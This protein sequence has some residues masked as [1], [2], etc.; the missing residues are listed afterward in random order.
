MPN[1]NV[2]A[3]R[4]NP[5][6]Q[7]R[8]RPRHATALV[9]LTSLWLGF[10]FFGV[11]SHGAGAD[12]GGAPQAVNLLRDPSFEKGDS[13][14]PRQY[15]CR[16]L[17]YM[18]QDESCGVLDDSAAY[19]GAKSLRLAPGQSYSFWKELREVL[20]GYRARYAFTFSVWLKAAQDGT[21]VEITAT[22]WAEDNWN[23]GHVTGHSETVGTGWARAIV[24][25]EMESG[26]IEVRIRN[27]GSAPVWA[28]AAQL[29]EGGEAHAFTELWHGT[30]GEALWDRPVAEAPTPRARPTA[31]LRLRVCPAAAEAPVIDGDLGDRAWRTALRLP[32]FRGLTATGKLDAQPAPAQTDVLLSRTDGVLYVGFRC[33]APDA[34]H[35]VAQELPALRKRTDSHDRVVFGNDSVEFFI[36]ADLDR[37]SY[38]QFAVDVLGQRFDSHGKGRAGWDGS[39]NAAVQ[40]GDREW[41]VELA[42][43]CALIGLAPSEAS[44]VGLAAARNRPR[45]GGES[46]YSAV[47]APPHAVRGFAPIAF[48][49]LPYH[50]RLEAPQ[51][52]SVGSV[53]VDVHLTCASTDPV[54]IE[55]EAHVDSG[56]GTAAPGTTGEVTVPV[57]ADAVL[58]L[59]V[60]L[61]EPGEHR[62]QVAVWEK[63][64]PRARKTLSARVYALARVTPEGTFAGPEHGELRL[65]V[66]AGT[67]TAHT[68]RVVRAGVPFPRGVLGNAAAVRLLGPAGQPVPCQKHV[69]ARWLDGSVMSLLVDFPANVSAGGAAEYTL[70]F[71]PSVTEPQREDRAADVIRRDGDLAVI[72]T[73]RLRFR[74]LAS[75]FPAPDQV[76]ADLDA[77]GVIGRDEVAGLSS[78]FALSVRGEDGTVY[79][80]T[81]PLESFELESVGPVRGAVRLT[82]HLVSADGTRLFGYIARLTAWHDSTCVRLDVTLLN[83]VDAMNTAIREASL[84]VP[85]F[86]VR[87]VVTEGDGGPVSCK[88]TGDD[89]AV[90]IMQL[91]RV[92]R[93]GE[94]F[95][96]PELMYA[97]HGPADGNPDAVLA[98]GE[99]HS[100]AVLLDGQRRLLVAIRD[101]WQ[102]HPQEV[103][104]RPGGVEIFLW[105][106]HEVRWL[107]MSVGIR[108]T[109][110]LFLDFA[111][112]ADAA[113]Q[114]LARARDLMEP[115]LVT[116]P[117]AWYCTSGVFGGTYLP[118]RPQR[119]PT[120]DRYLAAF[121]EG[122]IERPRIADL[123]GAFDYG[124]TIKSGLAGW[125]NNQT[126]AAHHLLVQ[127]IRTLEPGYH[128]AAARLLRH[129]ADSDT[130]WH[131]VRRKDF[132]GSVASPGSF[133]HTDKFPSRSHNWSEG[134]LDYYLLTGEPWAL[135]VAKGICDYLT[136]VHLDHM[137][138]G[139]M[140]HPYRNHGWTL[141]QLVRLYEV[142][143]EERYL[144][145]AQ[146]L[147]NFLV[148]AADGPDKG[149]QETGRSVFHGGTCCAGLWRY[150]ELSGDDAVRQ[151]ALRMTDW[152]YRIQP[153]NVHAYY[154]WTWRETVFFGPLAQA[155][156]AT[157]R[158]DYVRTAFRH[159]Y[160]GFDRGL[161]WTTAPFASQIMSSAEELG[162]GEPHDRA[163][164]TFGALYSHTVYVREDSDR[165]F[166]LEALCVRPRGAAPVRIVG[167][168]PKGD[169]VLEWEGPPPQT[170]HKRTYKT[171]TLPIPQDG[172]TGTYRF[173]VE[174]A[175]MWQMSYRCDLRKLVLKSRTY[176]GWAFARHY[177][178]VPE[179]TKSFR[180]SVNGFEAKPRYRAAAVVLNPDGVERARTVWWKTAPRRGKNIE[181]HVLDL[182]PGPA[183]TGRVWCLLTSSVPYIR[184]EGVPPYL[185]KRPE[186]VFVP[187]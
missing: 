168:G 67:G 177:F 27:T 178:L 9:A 54:A 21:P 59:E 116:C 136:R 102:Q 95:Q 120:F 48:G 39:W 181:P 68:N 119:Y 131:R 170:E 96:D 83:D 139:R 142:V 13:G 121:F 90:R 122:R 46:P 35:I 81:A 16:F 105:P 146:G 4:P 1:V 166:R 85:C 187:E 44:V 15:W 141:M 179:S 111:P 150:A 133:L 3:S 185:A 176:E 12:G 31:P 173:D 84:L 50:A 140:G 22:G 63:G 17:D 60:R 33:H 160:A 45:P 66:R 57:G 69:L 20:R 100:G 125:Q 73:G 180:I 158:E 87:E 52:C 99:R 126:M 164:D 134:A 10:P 47:F 108:K 128:R 156:A 143:R 26:L 171:F 65:T 161:I 71:G 127:F 32:Q 110:T 49:T 74:F 186:A 148:R 153:Q 86:G 182:R 29:C 89:E 175:S 113:R 38:Y 64:K 77:D 184:F 34:S 80:A 55:G 79:A 149:W 114:L 8:S 92:V 7:H 124:D 42:I 91:R 28:D 37:G 129:M 104:V 93:E 19:H 40:R 24:E 159:I 88:L 132:V 167:L 112:S 117:T 103:I 94:S 165:A 6:E 147:V 62:V 157:G 76:A 58:P 183:E 130:S 118:A 162:L 53:V 137:R 51:Y 41:T 23:Q 25:A 61:T 135:D 163:P 14:L 109:L 82:G 56:T 172:V 155:Y 43:P 115:P 78:P 11:C 72:D 152:L 75:Q 138:A 151:F 5:R 36:D 123:T 101:F 144:D 18:R 70:L 106:R 97:V 174:A 169:R 154:P 107:D 98:R 2:H 30:H 145:C